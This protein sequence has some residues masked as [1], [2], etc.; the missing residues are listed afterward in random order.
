[1]TYFIA[2]IISVLA[3]LLIARVI[4]FGAENGHEDQTGNTF[5]QRD[6]DD[7]SHKRPGYID[8]GNVTAAGY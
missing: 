1:M 5:P 2:L 7:G 3:S 6:A 4:S 8:A